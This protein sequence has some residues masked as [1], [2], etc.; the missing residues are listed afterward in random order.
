ME[1]LPCLPRSESKNRQGEGHWP[2]PEVKNRPSYRPTASVSVILRE[3]DGAPATTFIYV[4]SI[5]V[6]IYLII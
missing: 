4:A 2:F 6:H 1:K 3:R 5:L